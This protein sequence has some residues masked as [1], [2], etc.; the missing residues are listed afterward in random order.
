VVALSGAN[1]PNK[2]LV[3][4]DSANTIYLAINEPAVI[5]SGIRLNANGGAMVLDIEKTS[6]DIPNR[7]NAISAVAASNLCFCILI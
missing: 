7:I 1:G 2:I 4:N 6:A 5:N 3:T